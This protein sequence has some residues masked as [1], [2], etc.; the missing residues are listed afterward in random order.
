MPKH[1]P[2]HRRQINKGAPSG[3]MGLIWVAFGIALLLGLA[4]GVVWI[5]ITLL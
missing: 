3:V 4:S 2:A 1:Y 5:L